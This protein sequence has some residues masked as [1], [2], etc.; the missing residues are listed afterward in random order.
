MGVIFRDKN[1]KSPA[2]SAGDFPLSKA[3]IISVLH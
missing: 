1:K 2:I 3:F